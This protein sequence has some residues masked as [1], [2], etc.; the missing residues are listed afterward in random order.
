[1]GRVSAPVEERGESFHCEEKEQFP[2]FEPRDHVSCLTPTIG[3]PSEMKKI[4][5]SSAFLE[6]KVK[7]CF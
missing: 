3:V 2:V 4:K 6:T 7:Q 1:M 5:R